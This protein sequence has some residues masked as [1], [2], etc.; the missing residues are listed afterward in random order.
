MDSQRRLEMKMISFRE[1]DIQC[2]DGKESMATISLLQ[3]WN[4]IANKSFP[5]GLEEQV[6]PAPPFC[7]SLPILLP[8]TETN[9]HMQIPTFVTSSTKINVELFVRD[10]LY[11]RGRRGAVIWSSCDDKI[12]IVLDE[13][14]DQTPEQS[15]Y[16]Y[17]THITL[18]CIGAGGSDFLKPFIYQPKP[19][20]N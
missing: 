4:W 6:K 8:T 5:D 20:N 2:E 18:S 13:D 1:R 17:V 11:R 12:A 3:E 14:S 9:K 10:T 7:S 15:D 16:H 19:I